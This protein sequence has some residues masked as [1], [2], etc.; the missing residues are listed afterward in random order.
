MA[1]GL[2]TVLPTRAAEVVDLPVKSRVIESFR[3]G[4]D[5]TTFGSLEFVGGLE[6][7]SSQMLFGA[8]SAIRFRPD[9]EQF[10][11]IMDTGHW[12]TG[13]VTRDAAGR[14]SGI[15][16]L[17]ATAMLDDKG[18]ENVPKRV[19]DAEGLALR[20]GEVLA[21]YEGWARV[22]VYPDPGFEQSKP[23]RRLSLSMPAKSL[24]ANRG[25]ETLAV[26]P[27][28]SPLAGALVAITELARDAKG[29][30]IAEVLDGPRKGVF[31]VKERK[32]FA[33]TDGAFLPNGDLLILE[34][35]FSFAEGV[36]M[37]I[38]RIPGDSIRPGAVVDG[39]VILSAD[40]RSQIDN[41]EGLEVVTMPD[42][43][44]H[45]ILVSDDN[46]SILQRNLMLE[47]RLR[48]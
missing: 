10:V 43:A 27:A 4:S 24:P 38:R 2:A 9:R 36:G 18:R 46:H 19:M 7:T 29:N 37:E 22:D 35:R 40:M 6:M 32:P 28:S 34:R 12:L 39:E 41:M 23:L 48:D 44:V 13:R 16:D 8:V 47:F 25:L 15:A 14:L 31:A 21:S 11:A 33:I 17:K 5:Q 42:G 3:I 1:L 30:L 45:V 26:A 20:P